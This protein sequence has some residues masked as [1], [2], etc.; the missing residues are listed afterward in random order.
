MVR[1]FHSQGNWKSFGKIDCFVHVAK[2][3]DDFMVNDTQQIRFYMFE[4]RLFMKSIML[5][6]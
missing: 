5:S 4:T 1:F 2:R 6:F 3:K